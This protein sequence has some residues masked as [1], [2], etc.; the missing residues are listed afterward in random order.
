MSH[1]SVNVHAESGIRVGPVSNGMK[2][3]TKQSSC[4]VHE[5]RSD[6]CFV[7]SVHLDDKLDTIERW[8][9]ELGLHCKD[10]W[11]TAEALRRIVWRERRLST[12]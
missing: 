12:A 1:V 6:R 7:V 10:V 3:G 9:V 8:E 2:D 5:E 4:A 11:Y